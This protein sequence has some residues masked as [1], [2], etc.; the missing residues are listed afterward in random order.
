MTMAPM[1]GAAWSQRLAR[2]DGDRLRAYRENLDFYE[3]RQ[4]PSS[5]RA[6]TLTF[7]YGRTLIE[8]TASYVVSGVAYAVDPADGDEDGARRA[9]AALARVADENDFAQL[10]FDTEIDAAVLGDAAYKVWWDSAERRVRVGAPDVQGL[11]AWWSADD[12]ARVWRVASRYVLSAEEA[13]VLHGA[14]IARDRPS[15]EVEVIEVWTDDRFEL[16]I[17]GELTDER[18]NPY[19]FI[20]F[21]I[22]PNIREPKRF[23]GTSDLEAIKEPLRE[24]NRAFTQLSQILEISGNP[25]AVLENVNEARDIA[26]EPGAVWELPERARAYLLD[27]LQGGGVQLHVDYVN[28]IYRALHDLSEAPRT[29]FGDRGGALS[30]VALNIELDPLLKKVQRKRLIR[31]VAH[32]RRNELALRLLQQFTGEQFAPYRSRVLWGAL[33]PQDRSRA[34]ADARTLVDAGIQSRRRA[35]S[36]LG[37]EDPEREFERWLDEER[38]RA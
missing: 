38:R 34:V 23:W 2:M 13:H 11:F 33:L 8:K 31:S 37:V 9:E 12:I 15:A 14:P 36:D 19:G 10:D 20:P 17:G 35:A 30:G 1:T 5:T 27:L 16:W 7:N 29:A 4:W 22:F 21:V 6:R 18:P 26:V 24:L 25:I 3:G 28:L 32:R